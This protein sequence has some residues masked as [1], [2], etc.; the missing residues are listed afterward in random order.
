MISSSEKKQILSR[1]PDV[2][3]PYDKILHKKVYADVY[4][5]IP[6]GP[7]AF[8]WMTY[9]HGK[10]IC[11][12]MTLNSRGNVS[13]VDVMPACFNTDLSYGTILYGTLFKVG[14]L[15]HFSC[16]DI[17]FYKGIPVAN[18]RF[19]QKIE[20]MTD[21]FKNHIK[22]L[23]YTSNFL[24]MGFPLTK[25]NYLSAEI[26]IS[27]LPYA[28]YG[29]A[30]WSYNNSNS[31]GIHLSK[32]RSIPEAIFKVKATIQ[33]DIYNI[34]CFDYNG[35]SEPYCDAMIPT[36]KSSVMMNGLFRTIKEN[37]NLDRLEESDDDDEFE[38]INEDKFVDLNK[39]LVMRCVYSRRFRK[40]QPIGIITD[41]VKL[42]TRREAELFEKK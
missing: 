33:D 38:N 27:N 1:F 25:P 13:S 18:Y 9:W 16:E 6:K 24:I 30:L 20:I 19:L 14:D 34:Y 31:T 29:V 37:A 15:R 7:K 10:N 41:K 3:L 39:S 23:A 42:T 32:I 11:L 21:M 12:V 2:E 22:Q 5:L 26:E 28:V 17:H 4:F 35:P 36:Y 8:V 40:W